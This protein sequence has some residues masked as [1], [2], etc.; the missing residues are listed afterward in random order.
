MDIVVL[1]L[2]LPKDML[3]LIVSMLDTNY[4]FPFALTCK[5]FR[6][7]V[8]DVLNG[9]K[10]KTN[11]KKMFVSVPLLKWARKDGLMMIKQIYKN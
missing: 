7:A 8:R 6:T 10:M 2:A 3:E 5:K 11:V 1:L 9:K 4:Y